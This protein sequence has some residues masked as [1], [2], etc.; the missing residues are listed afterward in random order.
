MSVKI[1]EKTSVRITLAILLIYFVM[2]VLVFLY[3][4][5]VI[6]NYVIR[7]YREEV[8]LELERAKEVIDRFYTKIS[9]DIETFAKFPILEEAYDKLTSYLDLPQQSPM[10][11][12]QSTGYEKELYEIF[13]I[14]GENHSEIS[15]VYFGSETGGYLQWPETDIPAH[16]DPRKRPWYQAALETPGKVVTTDP[17]GIAVEGYLIISNVRTVTN[18][19]GEIIG[20]FGIDFHQEFLSKLLKKMLIFKDSYFIGFNQNGIIFIDTLEEKNFFKDISEIGIDQIEELLDEKREIKWITINGTEYLAEKLLLNERRITLLKIVP[21]SA[22]NEKVVSQVKSFIYPNLLFIFTLI[23]ILY[24]VINKSVVKPVENL[25]KSISL[26]EI[27]RLEPL[28]YV[29]RGD[30]ISKLFKTYNELILR[31]KDTFS[32]LLASHQ[33][34]TAQ[35]EELEAQYQTIRQEEE[36]ISELYKKLKSL[37]DNSPDGIVE[38]DS[39]HIVVNVNK[40]FENIFGY[41]KEECLGKNLD[42]ILM[43]EE[44]RR[45]A[46]EMTKKLFK[47]SVLYTEG[48]RYRKDGKPLYT[49]IRGIVIEIDGNV[50]GGFGIYTDLTE[51]KEYKEKLDYISLHDRLTDTYNYNFFIEELKRYSKSRDYPIGIFV[52]DIDGI[53]S[54]ND[55]WGR[56]TGD[57]LIVNL[58]QIIKNSF[59]TADII[60]RT[61]GDEFGVILPK[62]DE[63][64]IEEIIQRV[65]EKVAKFNQENADKGYILSISYGYAFAKEEKDLIQIF[66]LAQE[67]LRKQKL[68]RKKSSKSQTLNVLIAALGEK[69]DV[70]KGHTDRV[71]E[72][73]ELVGK[74]L[75]LA[76]DKMTNLM[77]LAEVHDLGKIGI[78]DRIL[79]KPGKLDDEE[80]EMMK[81]HTEIGYRIAKNSPELETIAEL[82]LKHHERWDGKGYPLGLKGEEIPIECR[83]LSVVDSFD[84]MTNQRPYN[85]PKTFEE[86]IEEIKKCSG[87]QYD[88]KVVEVFLKVIENWKK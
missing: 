7:E 38:F 41:T 40:A 80:W 55:I 70:T 11:P 81:K 71:A 23:V 29:D 28:E 79:M 58:A 26:S 76:K 54:I 16:Y 10:K 20:V 63:L 6:K 39:N 75:K 68:L 74:E 9:N 50:V 24:A 59:R 14:Y 17:Y 19:N 15:Y 48:I 57:V 12:S 87:A 21:L 84:A 13:R 61:G 37:F 36:K 35:N 43:P 42:E 49:L 67:S 18:K 60:A 22:V 44:Y 34:I 45:E 73:C 46:Q 32:N 88:P 53:Q 2:I 72:L 69:D 8:K 86:A 1:P 27:D 52:V 47:N 64:T 62:T 56:E 65:E 83:I 5:F 77:L 31:L 30:D 4:N 51:Q 33:E 66:K 82:I 25:S 85:K 78:P 3:A